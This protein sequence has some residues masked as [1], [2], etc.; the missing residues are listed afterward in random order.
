[1][2]KNR[3]VHILEP[4]DVEA[5]LAVGPHIF[6]FAPVAFCIS[7]ATFLQSAQRCAS[8]TPSMKSLVLTVVTFVL[9]SAI[10]S[11]RQRAIRQ[12]SPAEDPSPTVATLRGTT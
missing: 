4:L 1:L 6:G 12:K 11:S 9:I 7:R 10:F 3:L 5:S 2:L 8:A